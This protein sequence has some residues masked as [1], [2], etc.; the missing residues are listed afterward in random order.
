M[1]YEIK[2]WG[3]GG[4]YGIGSITKEQYDFWI[5]SENREYLADEARQQLDDELEV[6]DEARFEDHYSA[7][8]DIGVCVGPDCEL[9]MISIIDEKGFVIYEGKY[10]DFKD[11]YESNSKLS[12]IT[13]PDKEDGHFL[14]WIISEE[15]DFYI[16]TVETDIFKPEYLSFEETDIYGEAVLITDILYDKNELELEAG[17]IKSNDEE[18]I[19]L[20]ID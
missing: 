17:Y 1:K 5:D 16:T 12:E 4:R 9:A 18:F 3:S 8:D 14:F 10:Q 13:L 6:P 20:S 15:G 7:F 11:R 19:L 2:V